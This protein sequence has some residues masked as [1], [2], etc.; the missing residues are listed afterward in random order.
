MG[1]LQSSRAF[2]KDGCGEVAVGVDMARKRKGCS[3]GNNRET[4]VL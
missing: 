3:A 2:D 1:W 4:A